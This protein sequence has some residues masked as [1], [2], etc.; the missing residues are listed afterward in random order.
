M[1]RLAHLPDGLR[2]AA[3]LLVVVCL[4]RPQSTRGSDRIKHKGIDVVLVLDSI[5]RMARAYNHV[6][7][8]SGKTMSGGIDARAME[9]PKQ[10]FGSAREPRIR[11]LTKQLKSSVS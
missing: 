2:L 1:A 11:V 6:K 4:T 9:R 3:A 5:T 8:D 10:F 7:G